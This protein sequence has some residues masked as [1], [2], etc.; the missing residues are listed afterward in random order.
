MERAHPVTYVGKGKLREIRDLRSEIGFDLIVADDELTPTQ[1]RK[2]EDEIDVQVADRT[3]VILHIFARH[4]RTREG[5]LQVELAQYRYLLPR[6]TGRGVEL[7]R[8]GA[9]INTRGPGETKLE[10]DR[11]RI[12][13]RIATLNRALEDVRAQRSL[14]RRQ[15]SEAGLPVFALAGY[16]NAGKSTLMNSL[17]SA[18]VL[19]SNVLFAT[20][21][22]T[23]RQLELPNQLQVLL[24]DTVGFIQKLPAD[25]IAAFRATLEE[26]QE[27]DCIVHVL[28]VSHPDARSHAA[29]VEAELANLGLGVTPR[30]TV[31][32]KVDQLEPERLPMLIKSYD[33][34]VAM[35]ALTGQGLEALRRR[36]EDLVSAAYVPVKVLIPYA[37]A[38]AVNLFHRRG[39]VERETHRAAGTV[40]VGRLPRAL[41]ARFDE[42]VTE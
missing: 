14:H 34:G 3:A 29:T 15:R 7:S 10:T 16:T 8:L 38:E 9:G 25:L 5:K 11:R 35:S 26:L 13:T 32:N 19:S 33:D 17:T 36:L 39:V 1:Q 23:T 40:I 2:L 41:L 27:A 28:D 37:G 20:L 30:V 31:L 6:L 21:D 24:T 4:A 42:Y 18:Q 22:P 12:R